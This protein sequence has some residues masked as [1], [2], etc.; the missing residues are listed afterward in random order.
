MHC[1]VFAAD[2]KAQ[3]K[4]VGGIPTMTVAGVAEVGSLVRRL[5]FY[6]FEHISFFLVGS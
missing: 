4:R 3:V 1:V 5:R 2:I 6:F